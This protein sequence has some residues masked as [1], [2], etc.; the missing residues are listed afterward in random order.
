MADDLS[1]ETIAFVLGS[2]CGC[3]HVAMLPHSSAFFASGPY[4]VDN[5]QLC[6]NEE[7]N[8]TGGLPVASV[9]KEDMRR[10]TN[11]ILP[12]TLIS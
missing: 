10:I 12:F 6:Y 3:F 5:T 11:G 2:S 7:E 8:H 4:Q 9:R 1:G